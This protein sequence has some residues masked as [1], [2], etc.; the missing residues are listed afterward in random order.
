MSSLV[1]PH[2]GRLISR[3]LEGEELVEAK[4]EG[5]GA[6]EGADDFQG[7]IGSYYDRDG[8]L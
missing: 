5:R 8:R 3:L 2:G 7:D 6:A 1:P 4:K